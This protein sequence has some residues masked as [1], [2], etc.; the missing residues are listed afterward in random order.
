[1]VEKLNAKLVLTGALVAFATGLVSIAAL[2]TQGALAQTPTTPTGTIAEPAV[3]GIFYYLDPTGKK[4]PLEYDTPMRQTIDAQIR[5]EQAVVR[6]PAGTPFRFLVRVPPNGLPYI[7]QLDSEQGFRTIPLRYAGKGKLLKLTK[8]GKLARYVPFDSANVGTSSIIMTPKEPLTPGEY[9]T[10]VGYFEWYCFGVDPSS[11]L[12]SSEQA[13]SAPSGGA[14]MTN[15]DVIKMAS[16]GLSADVII[17]AIKGASSRHFDLSIDN[18]IALKQA[19]VP[20]PVVA[21]MQQSAA[22]APATSDQSGAFSVPNSKIQE[23]TDTDTGVFYAVDKTGK[24]VNLEIARPELV[25][26]GNR[27]SQQDESYNTQGDEA[28]YKIFGAR[29]PV[30]FTDGMVTLVIRTAHK[31][32]GFM[33]GFDLAFGDMDNEFGDLYDM[34]M[35]RWEP[36]EGRRQALFHTRRE[37][38][39][40]LQD[41]DPGQVDFW[42]EKLGDNFYK[43]NPIDPL[44]SGEYCLGL[45]RLPTDVERLYCFEIDSPR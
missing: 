36:V 8:G 42:M 22:S 4:V 34:Q 30:R 12:S 29:S 9:C 43:I 2:P 31:D 26:V 35:R 18:L 23:P 14:A 7:I 13:S 41:P 11:G 6:F 3:A 45:H 37:S 16:A 10:G 5:R 1:M 15:A 25:D 28:Y 33:R 21:A 17:S 27:F 20:D 19:K 44:V 39:Y 32:R 40:T 24:L 38:R